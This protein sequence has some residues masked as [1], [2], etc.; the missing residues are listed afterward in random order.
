MLAVSEGGCRQINCEVCQEDV[1]WKASHE[2]Y[3]A[4]RDLAVTPKR[5]IRFRNRVRINGILILGVCEREES[6]RGDG[7][8]G[9]GLHVV[10]CVG[11]KKS[12]IRKLVLMQL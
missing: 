10:D 2:T 11:C 7:G 4:L 12:T 5:A 8:G 6:A 9:E 1:L 3:G